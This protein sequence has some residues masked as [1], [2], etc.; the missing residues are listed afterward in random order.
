MEIKLWGVRGSIPTP[1]TNEQYT[2]KIE[3]ILTQA[4]ASKIKNKD[5]IGDFIE[6]LPYDLRY[7]SG[8]NTTC[9]TVT[10]NSGTQ[11]IIDAGTGIRKLGMELMDG[12]CGKGQGNIT[13]FITHNHW[14]HLQGLPFFI[15]SMVKGNNITFYSPYSNQKEILERQQAAPFFPATF[16]QYSSTKHF[17]HIDPLKNEIIQLEDDLTVEI[18]P[19]KHP[20]GSFAYK[21][22]QD[23]KIFIF[24]T[25]AEFTGESIEKIDDTFDFFYEAD[26]LVLDSQYTLDESFMKFDWGH[27]SNTMAVNCGIRWKIKNLILTHHEPSY[28]DTK[29]YH[30]YIDAL[31]HAKYINNQKTEIHLAREGMVFEL[32]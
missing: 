27:T 23:G 32:E 7:L 14:D 24:A 20:G 11:Y 22:K 21:F 1:L 2:D 17:I 16:D 19:L 4:I 30:N 28:D 10:S 9:A 29:L 12:P 25:D 18:Y 6:S 15:P 13:I 26:L 5:Q 8:G 31:E 3:A